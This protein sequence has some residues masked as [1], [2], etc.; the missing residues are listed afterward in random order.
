MRLKGSGGFHVRLIDLE[1]ARSGVPVDAKLEHVGTGVMTGDIELPAGTDELIPRHRSVED[2][3][4]AVEW[5]N[6]RAIGLA[7]NVGFARSGPEYRPGLGFESRRD[8]TAVTAGAG[9]GWRPGDE[10]AVSSQG[11]TLAAATY[12]R[13]GDSTLES[14]N[15]DIS[16]SLGLRS[17]HFFSA[18]LTASEDDLTQP[19]DLSD[20][21]GVP[22]GRYRA[23]EGRVGYTMPIR[24][25]LRTNVNASLGGFFDGTRRALTLSPFWTPTPRFKLT[26]TYQLNHI[27]FDARDQTF[28]AHVARAQT[29]LMFDTRISLS[30]LLQYNSAAD[31]FSVNARLRINPR[32]GTDLYL[33]YS[34]SLLTDL[35]SAAILPPRSRGRTLLVKFSR[36]L[37]P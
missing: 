18:G 36:T 37:F 35:G 8:F 6:T 23:V 24:Y 28:I 33:V 10:S 16:Y 30:G 19:F 31:D 13:N 5:R 26:G 34:E 4:L 29:E 1:H 25:P 21:A 3:F 7:Y 22:I 32:E 20:D 17:N 2:A 9:F 14:G 15:I 11:F 12:L 27:T